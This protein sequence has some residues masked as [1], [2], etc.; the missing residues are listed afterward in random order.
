MLSTKEW[1]RPDQWV[2]P[3]RAEHWWR[4]VYAS[5]DA[6]SRKPCL[7]ACSCCQEV[8]QQSDNQKVWVIDAA[9]VGCWDLVVRDVILGLHWESAD[10]RS[11]TA[12]I[13]LP[14]SNLKVLGQH[15]PEGHPGVNKTLGK[16]RQW[17]Y[18]LHARNDIDSWC[19]QHNTCTTSWRTATWSQGS[20]ALVQICQS[21]IWEDYHQHHRSHSAQPEGKLIPPDC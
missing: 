7:E 2:T 9:V 11:K 15:P 16:G 21:T 3:A 8:G 18:R 17:Y 10:G 12:K 19:Q 6:V 4:Q 1:T 14:H 5:G 20:Y 13:V